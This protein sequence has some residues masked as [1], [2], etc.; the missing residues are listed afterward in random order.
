MTGPFDFIVQQAQKV[1]T[2]MGKVEEELAQ[3]EITGESGAGLVKVIMNG[4]AQVKAV[5]VEDDLLKEEKS[6][7]EDLLAAAVTDAVNKVEQ[8]KQEKVTGMASG[9]DFQQFFSMKP[10]KD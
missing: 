7:L 3:T 9:I 10:D 6:V 1:Q 8:F 5:K 2:D 4:R